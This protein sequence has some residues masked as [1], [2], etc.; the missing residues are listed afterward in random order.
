[1]ASII[2]PSIWLDQLDTSDSQAVGQ[3]VAQLFATEFPAED[4]STI[5]PWFAQVQRMFAGQYRN[6]QAMDT[7][8][9]D[10]DHTLQAT[11][12][13]AQIILRRQQVK[14]HPSVSASDFLTG[15]VAILFHDL[16][17][18][19]DRKDMVGTG[20][21]FTF[22]HEQRSCEIAQ[23]Y[24][25]EVG[26]SQERIG[27]VQHL[28]SCTGP[29]AQIGSIP[30]ADEVEKVL[31]AA[32]CTAD[33]LGQMSDAKYVQ[34][35]PPLFQEFEEADNYRGVPKEK[36]LFQSADEILRKTPGFWQYVVLPKLEVDCLGVYRYLSDPY[37][38]GP[39]PYVQ[40][41]EANIEKIRS[42]VGI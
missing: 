27:K 34:K 41:I 3:C 35:L 11:L 12:C 36:R 2:S 20:A 22:V 13:W 30:F 18:L 4:V 21:K 38:D 15:M 9:H 29:R 42:L 10:L 8:Y 25:R 1:M 33:Y 39:N 16:G 31:G 28:I 7:V 23:I 26:W 5:S 19:K 32:V 17:Y 40:K 24:L 14:V 6:Y 37:P